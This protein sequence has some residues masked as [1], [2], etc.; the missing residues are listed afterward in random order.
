MKTINLKGPLTDFNG[1]PIKEGDKDSSLSKVLAG[2]LANATEGD[3]VKMWDWA[4]ALHKEGEIQ[5][6]DSDFA[7]IHDFVKSHKALTVLAK[8]QLLKAIKPV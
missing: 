5:V 3:S 1:S 4:V 2:A 8:G 7:F 6:D